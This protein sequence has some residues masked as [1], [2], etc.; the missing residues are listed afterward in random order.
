MCYAQF[1][2]AAAG[3]TVKNLNT[4]I[5]SSVEIPL[6]ALERQVEIAGR[7]DAVELHVGRKFA[8]LAHLAEQL[9]NSLTCSLMEIGI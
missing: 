2:R 3:A 8:L 1:A 5:V 9:S 4:S 7:L 6:P